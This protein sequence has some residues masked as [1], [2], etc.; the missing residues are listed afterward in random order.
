[1]YI[2]LCSLCKKVVSS[3]QRRHYFC[4]ESKHIYGD[5]LT[6]QGTPLAHLM[7]VRDV[8]TQWNSTHAMIKHACILQ[9]AST[10]PSFDTLLTMTQA[11]DY[12]A[13]G[14]AP[15]FYLV[16]REWKVL[17]QLEELLSVCACYYLCA[18]TY[19]YQIFTQVTLK[20]SMNKQPTLCWVLP[21]YLHMEQKMYAA[22]SDTKL[23]VNIRDAV[24]AALPKLNKYYK[25][26]KRNK[27]NILA[28]SQSYAAIPSLADWL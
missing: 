25:M 27:N 14:H 23:D 8:K 21:M 24:H 11:L 16:E 28:T 1:M 26:A 20:M 22:A 5:T 15:S 18:C 7:V 2:Q 9:K 6:P 4:E 13:V 12:F 10:E 3:P 19:M 17:E